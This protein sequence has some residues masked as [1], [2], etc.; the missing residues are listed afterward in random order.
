MTD[1]VVMKTLE[2]RIIKLEEDV[3]NLEFQ[4]KLL[5][6]KI[7][8]RMAIGE[9]TNVFLDVVFILLSFVLWAITMQG[10]KNSKDVEAERNQLRNLLEKDREEVQKYKQMLEED[11]MRF[12][13]EYHNTIEETFSKINLNKDKIEENYRKMQSQYEDIIKE[14]KGVSEYYLELVAISHEPDLSERVFEYEKILKNS[15]KYHLSEEE[16]GRLHYYLSITLYQLATKTPNAKDKMVLDWVKKASKYIS[17]AISLGG[18]KG[19]Y[20]Y[21]KA[22]IEL[23]K[24]RLE[25]IHNKNFDKFAERIYEIEEYFEIAFK[26]ADVEFYMFEEMI[27]LLHLI[28]EKL[29]EKESERRVIYDLISLWC[30]RAKN[31]DEALYKEDLEEIKIEVSTKI[32]EQNKKLDT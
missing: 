11:R 14:I 23:E 7:E 16:K 21:E 19:I 8:G 31:F 26:T 13:S 20:F 25:L 6:E 32:E 30:D 12:S 27:S 2:G 5:E 10:W 28:S 17:N 29:A 24:Y 9:H 1:A 15:E 3:T 4:D 22:K 18:K